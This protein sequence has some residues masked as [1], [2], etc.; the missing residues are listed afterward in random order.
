MEDAPP[1]GLSRSENYKK[2]EYYKTVNLVVLEKSLES[3]FAEC[4]NN[5]L[6]P[7]TR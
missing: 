6:C 5:V 3:F 7:R 4:R 2:C 1:T